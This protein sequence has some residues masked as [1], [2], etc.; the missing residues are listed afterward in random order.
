MYTLIKRVPGC[1]VKRYSSIV[2]HQGAIQI[3]F[4][5]TNT[6]VCTAKTIHDYEDLLE[7]AGLFVFTNLFL[8]IYF[9]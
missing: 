8:S 9:T 2:R 6:L 1:R 5:L 4:L 3:S 7:D